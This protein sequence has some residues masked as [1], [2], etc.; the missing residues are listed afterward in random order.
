MRVWLRIRGDIGQYPGG[1]S[2]QLTETKRSL[3]ELGLSCVCDAEMLTTPEPCDIVH[4][5]NTTRIRE[6]YA[7]FCEAQRSSTPV[8][9]STIWHSM[10]EIRRFMSWRFRL[11]WFP[12]GVYSALREGYYSLRCRQKI[13]WSS[14]IGYRAQQRAVVEKAD[15]ILPNSRA[16]LLVLERE[17]KTRPRAAFVIPNGVR[18]AE[19]LAP[20]PATGRRNVL[21]VGRIEP[22]KNQLAVI[23]A[24]LKIA[25]PGYRLVLIGAVNRSH[26]SYVNKVFSCLRPGLVEYLGP[27]PREELFAQYRSAR[28]TVLASF[29]ETTGLVVLEALAH[30][31]TAVVLDSPYTR[32]YFEGFAHFCDPY[33]IESIGHA[34]Q[35]AVVSR[36]PDVSEL[37][38]R[39]SWRKAG[40]ATLEAYQCVLRQR[41]HET[42]RC[43]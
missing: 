20:E 36:V 5:F 35:D 38:Q 21:C 8:V 34:I 17:L 43:S 41:E 22:R 7:Q 26:S 9:V 29:Y 3:E 13:S 14:V 32:E 25:L 37:L 30:G 27:L 40:E 6:T 39:Y 23:R 31:A 12:V 18:V 24:F 11:P 16:E 28:T 19:S 10:E 42:R 1:D 15:A 2:Q 33:R 4:L